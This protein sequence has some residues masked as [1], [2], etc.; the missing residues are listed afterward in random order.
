MKKLISPI[1]LI[2]KSLRIYF[3]RENFWYLTKILLVGV[4]VLVV[5]LVVFAFMGP[6]VK[7]FSRDFS[8]IMN[9]IKAG[10]LSFVFLLMFMLLLAWGLLLY[11]AIIKSVSLVLAGRT[12]GVAETL[13]FSRTRVWKF[14]PLFVI[15]FLISIIYTRSPLLLTFSTLQTGM[16]SIL[17]GV[18]TIFLTFAGFII[19]EENLNTFA[20]IKKS[21][22]LV[23]ESLW[24]VLGR[25]LVINLFPMGAIYLLNFIQPIGF[26][27]TIF[28]IPY[29]FLLSYLLYEDIKRVRVQSES[30]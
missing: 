18:F 1:D 9:I 20:A 23:K 4:A 5:I 15:H 28:F 12:F 22:A 21:I 13:K 11:V 25:A 29:S 14:L 30:V 19:V 17:L 3:K 10:S 27:F 6:L 26:L 16:F 8:N 2:K 24:S 7:N